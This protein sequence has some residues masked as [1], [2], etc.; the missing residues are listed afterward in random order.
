MEIN[1]TMSVSHDKKII[2]HFQ[3][4]LTKV[5]MDCLY[6]LLKILTKCC[7]NVTG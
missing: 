4:G 6:Q 1:D 2:T 3:K 7:I 5:V